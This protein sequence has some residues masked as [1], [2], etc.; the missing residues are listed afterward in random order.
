MKTGKLAL[1]SLILLTALNVNARA[2]HEKVA[3]DNF[4]EFFDHNQNGKIS[5]IMLQD[6]DTE[7]YETESFFVTESDKA[8]GG[9]D[10]V[11][12]KIIASMINLIGHELMTVK[13][14]RAELDNNSNISD[15]DIQPIKEKL[16]GINRLIEEINVN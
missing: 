8:D 6:V 15:G 3:G 16:V 13:S 5:A 2:P 4:Q 7:I 12:G 1:I 9:D 10:L 14:L 11:E